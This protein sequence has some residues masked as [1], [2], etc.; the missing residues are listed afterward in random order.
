[1]GRIMPRLNGTAKWLIPVIISAV[2]GAFIVADRFGSP[3]ATKVAACEQAIMSHETRLK[4]VEVDTACVKTE[5]GYIKETL[6]R[7]ECKLDRR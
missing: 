4:T 3:T 6:E 2:L 7:I 1:M 5:L